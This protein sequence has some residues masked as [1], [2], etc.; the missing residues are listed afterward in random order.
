[1]K[2]ILILF[3]CASCA[4]MSQPAK[5]ATKWIGER[6]V[7]NNDTLTV[8]E[9]NAMPQSVYLSNGTSVSYRFAKKYFS[10]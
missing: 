4:D 6:I 2:Y 1:M 7:I 10:Q 5:E 3:I 9:Y 8:M